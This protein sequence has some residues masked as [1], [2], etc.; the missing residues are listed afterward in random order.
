MFANGK[1]GKFCLLLCLLVTVCL[2]PRPLPA[3]PPERP[4]VDFSLARRHIRIIDAD[5]FG[6]T[7]N[8]LNDPTAPTTPETEDFGGI[9]GFRLYRGDHPGVDETAYLVAGGTVAELMTPW[10][11]DDMLYVFA[12][13]DAA[14]PGDHYYYRLYSDYGDGTVLASPA[15]PAFRAV[16]VDGGAADGGAGTAEDPFR[17]L[18]LGL[19]ALVEGGTLYIAGGVY[20]LDDDP[21][22]PI[23]FERWDERVG[24]D[25][26]AIHV[27]NVRV[28]GS[29][30]PHD[31]R[32]SDIN[33]FPTVIDAEERWAAVSIARAFWEE[34]GWWG[35]EMF[36]FAHWDDPDMIR[37][38]TIENLVIRNAIAFGVRAMYGR[39]HT[40]RGCL[41]FECTVGAWGEAVAATHQHGFTVDR[42]TIVDNYSVGLFFSGDRLLVRDS[43]IAHN[44]DT[45]I[46]PWYWDEEDDIVI[47]HCNLFGNHPDYRSIDDRTGLLG[48]LSVSPG[49][50]GRVLDGRRP[51][52]YR[53][54]V[55]SPCVGAASD[56]G[57]MG[58]LG[59]APPETGIP[60][61]ADWWAGAGVYDWAERGD[62]GPF[63]DFAGDGLAN[64]FRFIRNLAPDA[65]FPSAGGFAPA[66]LAGVWDAH[67]IE[68][69]IGAGR[70]DPGV[71]RAM[72]TIDETGRFRAETAGGGTETG[73]AHIDPDGLVVFEGWDYSFGALDPGRNLV[74]LGMHRWD[75]TAGV[76]TNRFAA[77][78][79]RTSSD[80]SPDELAGWFDRFHFR[81]SRD[82]DAEE[83]GV[84][85]VSIDDQGRVLFDGEEPEIARLNLEVPLVGLF[86]A[87]WFY[88]G[89]EDA[90]GGALGDDPAVAIAQRG[91]GPHRRWELD[92]GVRRGA[93][94]P[95][96]RLAGRWAVVGFDRAGQWLH[97]F[98]DLDEGGQAEITA[99]PGLPGAETVAGQFTLSAAG[100]FELAVPGGGPVRRGRVNLAGD[101][102]VLV[103][104]ESGAPGENFDIRV[105]VRTFAG[106]EPP[107]PEIAR[108]WPADGWPTRPV[109][110]EITGDNFLPGAVAE[111]ARSGARIPGTGTSVQDRR[112][113]VTTFDITGRA[114]GHYDIRVTNPDGRAG[115]LAGGFEIRR[116]P[117]PV[118]GTP[119]TVPGPDP[120]PG[121][122]EDPDPAEPEGPRLLSLHLSGPRTMRPGATAR[123]RVDVSSESLRPVTG[124]VATI[125]LSEEF[126]A[127]REVLSDARP[128]FE[129]SLDAISADAAG[130]FYFEAEALPDVRPGTLGV[131]QVSVSVGGETCDT[132]FRLVQFTAL[133]DLFVSLS[134]TPAFAGMPVRFV[135]KVGLAGHH[136]GTPLP[137]EVREHLE[138][139]TGTAAVFQFDS[140]LGG[141]YPPV[142]PYG[143][144]TGG[145]FTLKR[146]TLTGPQL[147]QAL[148]DPECGGIF[149]VSW[150][151]SAHGDVQ[152]LFADGRVYPPPDLPDPNPD[153]N[154]ALAVLEV[155]AAKDPNAIYAAPAAFV[156]PGETI[157]Y[158][159]EFENEREG[160]VPGEFGAPTARVETRLVLDPALEFD[161]DTFDFE[162]EF[163]NLDNFDP[164]AVL[165][166]SRVTAD[167]S[168]SYNPTSRRVTW[169]FNAL[170]LPGRPFE[171]EEGEGGGGTLLLKTRVRPDTPSG[172]VITMAALNRFLGLPDPESGVEEEIDALETDPPAVHLVDGTPP[173]S[174]LSVPATVPGTAFELEWAAAD[175]H[176][177]LGRFSVY[178]S[179]DDGPFTRHAELKRGDAGFP[180]QPLDGGGERASGRLAFSGEV[181]VT[182]R[183]YGIATDRAGNVQLPSAPV[184]VIAGM[185][186]GDLTGDGL[187]TVDDALAALRIV[188]GLQAPSARELVLGDLSGTGAI[189]PADVLAILRRAAGID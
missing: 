104:P 168:T 1:S 39:N 159:V 40:L 106:L 171:G 110:V 92:F 113:I 112:R 141:L 188:L 43:I 178:V 162:P 81:L 165:G 10:H 75:V 98:V 85:V 49:F 175:A 136:P 181:G 152:L 16:H 127:G 60:G 184:T 64:L 123:F 2:L 42:C 4:A 143:E 117:P 137:A 63:A 38:V 34:P 83:A 134:A 114:P 133:Y 58:A 115:L 47:S 96:A 71:F 50:A 44:W 147:A 31:W 33:I 100:A 13:T 173:E 56:G 25:G 68:A 19:E 3:D 48:N 21:T 8:W 74:V 79:R 26:L 138:A 24:N 118:S 99:A 5:S 52:D 18:G 72:L 122:G 36:A 174:F 186:E 149:H 28:I 78:T 89:P 185:L 55:S 87:A 151:V 22:L 59:V 135:C 17:W 161:D 107:A 150:L 97:A 30:N 119:G 29:C 155:E 172:T 180:L 90:G 20:R 11:P 93:E 158:T 103:G 142:P 45:G 51:E 120:D 126:R 108:A 125:T 187:V 148:A 101:V 145:Q 15:L 189:S 102:I 57:N 170:F 176:S 109:P 177:G 105:M 70:R 130:R 6:I 12:A 94:I 129:V 164:E 32:Q 182:Y 27:S 23:P 111:L 41:V 128:S 153:N 139:M 132:A 53:L 69:V 157:L 88:M 163:V 9:T 167:R 95:P 61:W 35:G 37:N 80:V 76:R 140:Q 183:F 66:D 179:A 77:L 62:T 67:G 46:D 146:F 154:F 84:A 54:S 156:R 65:A 144:I 131:V 7:W 124:A 73:R 166:L 160:S 121:N 14:A 169:K 116:L 82:A 86:Y 91:D